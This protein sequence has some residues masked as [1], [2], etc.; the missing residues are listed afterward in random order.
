MQAYPQIEAK[1]PATVA[2]RNHRQVAP[3]RTPEASRLTPELKGFIDRVVVP[4]LVK[5]YVADVQSKKQIAES[6]AT[7]PSCGL[8]ISTP[9]AGAAR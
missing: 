8:M 1:H 7:V 5:S 4:I 6:A 9:Q 3:P 2:P